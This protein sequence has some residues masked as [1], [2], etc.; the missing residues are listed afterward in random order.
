LIVGIAICGIVFVDKNDPWV[1]KV[2]ELY[3][4]GGKFYFGCFFL[5][6][7]VYLVSSLY[8]FRKNPEAFTD[9]LWKYR[10]T[11][12]TLFIIVVGLGIVAG[13][14]D[15]KNWQ[16]LL[17]LTAFVIFADLG[18]FKTP[19]ITK[20]WSAEFQHRTKIEKAIEVN[21]DF[22]KSTSMK[23]QVFSDVIKQ[24]EA[25]FEL[26]SAIPQSWNDYQRELKQYLHLYTEKFRFKL[27]LVL[28]YN[29]GKNKTKEEIEVAKVANRVVGRLNPRPHGERIP[30]T[31]VKREMKVSVADGFKDIREM[32]RKL[33]HSL[34]Q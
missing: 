4:N 28:W 24:T 21:E 19:N 14:I 6:M 12:Y 20:I 8:D 17:Q 13:Y 34:K 29:M 18:V 27:D 11:Y 15:Y 16:I 2:I 1:K 22:I 33:L 3:K 10:K 5:I 23:F 7:G 30:T 32:N 31:Q 25:Y 26:K 9:D